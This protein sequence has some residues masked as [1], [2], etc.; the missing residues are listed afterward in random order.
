MNDREVAEKGRKLAAEI[1]SLNQICDRSRLD[2]LELEK[3]NSLV[4]IARSMCVDTGE[5]AQEQDDKSFT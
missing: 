2:D 4:E 5:Y 3:L 1:I